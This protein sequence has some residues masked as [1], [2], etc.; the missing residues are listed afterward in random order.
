MI[1]L[2]VRVIIKRGEEILLCKSLEQGHY[3]LPGGHVEFGDTLIETVYKELNE[4]IGLE[5][6]EIHDIVY[7]DF[8]EV[9]YVQKGEKH[10]EVN[11][12]FTASMN[13]DVEVTS[14]EDHLSFSWTLMSEI[15]NINF[16]PKEMVSFLK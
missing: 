13:D 12:I 11:M 1:E 3:F 6:S 14:K 7:K 5:K 2:I 4:E 9:M 16:L 10:H 8:L 15:P